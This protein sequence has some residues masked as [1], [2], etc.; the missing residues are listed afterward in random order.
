MPILGMNF[1]NGVGNFLGHLSIEQTD[2]FQVMFLPCF[3]FLFTMP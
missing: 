1:C 3:I 2:M